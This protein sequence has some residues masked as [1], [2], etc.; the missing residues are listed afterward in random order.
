[1]L[2]A[3]RGSGKSAARAAAAAAAAAANVAGDTGAL[4]WPRGDSPDAV[5][6][7]LPSPPLLPPLLR[8]LRPRAVAGGGQQDSGNGAGVRRFGDSC[9]HTAYEEGSAGAAFA[10]QG[11]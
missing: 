10:P 2:G 7:S 3:S 4:G 11:T 5:A 6:G 9:S 8:L 1:V